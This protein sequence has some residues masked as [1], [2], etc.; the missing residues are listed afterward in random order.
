MH[1]ALPGDSRR[2]PN[3]L[4]VARGRNLWS[5]LPDAQPS[6]TLLDKSCISLSMLLD[7]LSPFWGFKPHLMRGFWLCSFCSYMLCILLSTVANMGTLWSTLTGSFCSLPSRLLSL[8]R[9]PNNGLDSTYL[10]FIPPLLLWGFAS[11][12]LLRRKLTIYLVSVSP[13]LLLPP[14]LLIRRITKDKGDDFPNLLLLSFGIALWMALVSIL[15]LDNGR[16]CPPPPF[17]WRVVEIPSGGFEAWPAEVFFFSSFLLVQGSGHAQWSAEL[18]VCLPL[19]S[20]SWFSR[21]WPNVLL[22]SF[23]EILLAGELG[24]FFFDVFSPL[25]VGVSG[26]RDCA[27][28]K[29]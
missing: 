19:P 9:S 5:I 22:G 13:P 1:G 4:S 15:W 21:I 7:V 20:F 12:H 28:I 23:C 16:N 2:M 27:V 8:T 10:I 24:I 14:L 29:K 17:F 26:G 18:R 6:P 25:L 3:A 11:P